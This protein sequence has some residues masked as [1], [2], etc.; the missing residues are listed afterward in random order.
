M[1]VKVI[2]IPRNKT[3]CIQADDTI[4]QALNLIDENGLLS[5]PVVEGTKVFGILSKRYVYEQYFNEENVDRQEFLGRSVRDFIKTK[6]V[7]ISEDA[8]IEDAAQMFIGFKAPFIPVL[9]KKEEMVGIITSQ[10]IFKEYQKVFGTGEHHTVV[11]SMHDV[12]GGFAELAETLAKSGANI[13]NVRQR[14]TEILG[15]QEVTVKIECADLEKVV[16]TLKKKDFNVRQVI[17]ANK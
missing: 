16:N 2:M 1:K 14:D 5:L 4:A 15:V 9:D 17:P 3:K 8:Q 12:K 11:L 10:A 13:K 7:T 6:L